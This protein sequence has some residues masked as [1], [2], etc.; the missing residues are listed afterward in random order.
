MDGLGCERRGGDEAGSGEWNEWRLAWDTMV[1]HQARKKTPKDACTHD[2]FFVTYSVAT[3]V[4][5]NKGII[6]AL[7]A[8]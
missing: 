4:V 6:V 8:N 7:F 1:G 5:L 3:Y 2:V